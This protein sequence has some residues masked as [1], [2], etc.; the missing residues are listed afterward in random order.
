[1]SCSECGGRWS[2][3]VLVFRSKIFCVGRGNTEIFQLEYL[4]SWTVKPVVTVK[5][6]TSA[7]LTILLLYLSKKVKVKQ[8]HY[9][10]GQA[11]GVP[12]GSQISRQSAYE[13]GKVSPTHRPPLP[14]FPPRNYSWYLLLLE[15]ESIPG[16]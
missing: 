5:L 13:G 3:A 9:R 2:R 7:H 6:R 11:H 16:P 8:S 14:P 15:A 10:P 12:G 4:I 1:M